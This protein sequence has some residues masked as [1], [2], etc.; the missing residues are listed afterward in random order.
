SASGPDGSPAGFVSGLRYLAP[1]LAVGMALVGS[2]FGPRGSGARW[3]AMGALLLLAPFTIAAGDGWALRHWLIAIAVGFAFWVAALV[4]VAAW[5]PVLAPR[6]IR[7]SHRTGMVALALA[8]LVLL[9]AGQPVQR[10]Y[11]ENR[12]ATPEFTTPG[13]GAAFAWARD[14]KDE[15][16]G[17]VATRQY[18]LFGLKVDN[19]VQFVG[20]K[21]PHGGFIRAEACPA[22]REAVNAGGYRYLVTALDRSGGRLKYPREAGWTATD[23]ASNE[24][25]REKGAVIFELDGPLD[26]GTCR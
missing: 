26:P 2:G 4:L 12:Y 19:E 21:Q 1:A 20:V 25:L 24:V 5:R 7:A 16:I 13:L 18:P 11:F 9:F 8:G 15:R 6:W 22:F 3:L 14:V 17:T 23:P 10:H